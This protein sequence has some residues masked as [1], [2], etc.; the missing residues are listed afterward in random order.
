MDLIRDFA[1]WLSTDW[2]NRLGFFFPLVL[3]GLL[4]LYV[5]WLVVGY[6]RVSQIGI[7]EKQAE[8]PVVALP[9]SDG[10]S[11]SERPRGVPYCA[12]DQLQYPVG[13]RFCTRCERDLALDCTN[14]GAT[15]SAG[16]ASC[17]R[18]GTRT[19]VA[20]AALLS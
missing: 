15:L 16:D 12:F 10:T 3:L 20:D 4:G 1:D 8:Q 6:L 18:C 14:C 2:G 9:S 5:L 7:G 11:S 19:G 13:A 17:Y